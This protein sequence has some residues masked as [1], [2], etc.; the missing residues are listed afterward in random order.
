MLLLTCRS[1]VQESTACTPALLMLG[2]ELRNPAELTFGRPPDSLA[3]PPGSEYARRLQDRLESAHAPVAGPGA[4]LDR[5]WL[6]PCR[7]LEGLGEVV[8]RVQR[9]PR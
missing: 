2:R 9:P 4:E 8:Y 7:A 6:G 5:Q 1:A 3:I